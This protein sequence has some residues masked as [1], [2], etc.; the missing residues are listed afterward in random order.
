MLSRER[1]KKFHV[2][3]TNEFGG[4]E[5][6]GLVATKK[7][8]IN[9]IT[10]KT[11]PALKVV[12]NK[13]L[14]ESNYSSLNTCATCCK[15]FKGTELY[16]L[17]NTDEYFPCSNCG[18][19]RYCSHACRRRDYH[20]IHRSECII[21]R[22]YRDLVQDNNLEI[23]EITR[24]IFRLYS[25]CEQDS[26]YKTKIL[27]LTSHIESISK[28]GMI[29]TLNENLPAIADAIFNCKE[30]EPTQR[31][32]L[33][34]YI[35]TLVGIALVNT[36]NFVDEFDE[37]IGICIDPLFSMINHSCI[38]NTICHSD[39]PSSFY[40]IATNTIESGK[41]ITTNYCYIS[42]PKEIRQFELMFR[43]YFKCQCKLCS[44]KLDLFFS[45]NCPN[46]S[47]L[48]CGLSFDMF[49]KVDSVKRL[50]F[51]NK[52]NPNICNG[53]QSKID[54]G[55]LEDINELHKLLLNYLLIRNS[56]LTSTTSNK[57]YENI[58]EFK[59]DF[60]VS[61]S[62]I[63]MDTTTIVKA[64][65]DLHH[66]GKMIPPNHFQYISDVLGE[67]IGSRFVPEFC[68]PLNFYSTEI[69]YCSNAFIEESDSYFP[70]SDYNIVDLRILKFIAFMR[71]KIA[72]DIPC[73]LTEAKLSKFGHFTNI[74]N[75][76]AHVINML[77]ECKCHSKILQ[78]DNKSL[79]ILFVKLACFFCLQALEFCLISF[80]KSEQYKNL[81]QLVSFIGLSAT[82][83]E[84]PQEL[85]DWWSIKP[86][87]FCDSMFEEELKFLFGFLKIPVIIK[88]NDIKIQ[89]ANRDRKSL[90]KKVENLLSKNINIFNDI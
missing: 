69:S 50:N 23:D 20:D 67:V 8:E 80:M 77:Y 17:S 49:F 83:N 61:D 55:K 72:V 63:K 88:T 82:K 70:H 62:L 54:Y 11:T 18:I 66:E 2:K 37:K 47:S 22:S 78:M 87:S 29:D 59:E 65:S 25:R 31:T 26:I 57:L 81:T 89:F 3:V 14:Y 68:Y 30:G 64:C 6:R 79:L 58:E 33:E 40:V 19:Y 12:N 52:G 34:K 28:G 24:L 76:V 41:Q 45:Y 21:I 53:C 32:A 48:L 56:S 84:A 44:Q 5:K 15:R 27:N 10:L 46:C 9:S 90:F 13:C 36:N 60:K 42:Q 16:A 74:C 43:F 7:F 51:K 71:E 38:P 73:D 1:S 85:K 4:A 35:Q 39:S 75:E 86:K